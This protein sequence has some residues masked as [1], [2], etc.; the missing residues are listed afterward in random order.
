MCDVKLCYVDETGTDGRSPLVAFVG[1]IADVARVHRTRREFE[2]VFR[3]L[4]EIPDRAIAELK[5]SNIYYGNG[6]WSGV[7]GEVRHAAIGRLCEWLSDRKHSLALTALSVAEY[8]DSDLARLTGLDIWMSGALHIALQV[9]KA[10]Q[11]IGKL[12]GATFLVFDQYEVKGDALAELLVD[13]PVWSDDYYSRGRKQLALDQITDTAFYARSHHIGL[14]QVA[15]VFA[16]VFRRYSEICD[17]GAPEAYDAEL[18]RLTGWIRILDDRLL[19]RSHRW[20]RRTKSKLA[21]AYVSSCPP[22]LLNLG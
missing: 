11:R 14:V 16:F 9:Q 18:A 22:S 3:D 17:Y 15:D 13:P 20:P 7:D 10:H 8:R 6:R 1:V 4:A 2:E 12:K 21:K 19:D 5:G